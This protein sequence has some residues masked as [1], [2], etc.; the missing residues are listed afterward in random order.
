MRKRSTEIIQAVLQEGNKGLNLEKL[1]E[2]YKV[3]KKTLR[4]DINEIN[5]FLRTISAP[6]LIL[7]ERG[8][9]VKGHGFD[10]TLV[11]Q[12]L[13]EMNPYTY[14]LSSRERQIYIMMILSIGGQYMTMQ[15]IAEELYVS[16]ITI[17]NDIEAVKEEYRSAGVELMM[18]PGKGMLL[19]CTEDERVEILADLYREIGINV[20]NDGFFQRM[21][22]R[23]MHI[24]FEFSSIFS[25]MQDYMQMCS[26]VF[27]EDVFYEIALYMFVVFNFCL[28]VGSQAASEEAQ[29]E[30]EHMMLHTGQMLNVNVTQNMLNDLRAYIS[31]HKLI[32]FVKKVDEIELYKVVM[33]FV[34]NLEKI[35]HYELSDDPKLLDSLLMHIKNMKNWG[36][37]QVEFPEEYESYINYAHLEQAVAENAPILEQFLGYELNDNMKKSIVIHICVSII[38]NHRYMARASVIIVCPGS[39]ATGKYVEAQ[40]RNY[41]D[42]NIV[43]V[44]AVKEVNQKLKTLTAKVD[45]IISTVSLQ[46]DYCPVIK[47]HPFL[48]IE[49]L[50]LIQKVTFQK[51]SKLPFSISQKLSMM[52]SLIRD[53]IEDRRLAEL[54]CD[55]LSEVIEDYQASAPP[56][57]K[58]AIGELLEPDNILITEEDLTWRQAMH[59]ASEPLLRAGYIR[60]E[61]IE[62]AIQNVEEYGDYIV[63]SDGVA[64][65]HASKD[66]GVMK[67]CLSLLISKNGI[68]FSERS[69]RVYLLFCFASSGKNPYLDTLNEIMQIGHKDGRVQKIYSLNTIQEIYNEVVYGS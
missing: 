41:F 16:R 64:L 58:N 34:Q 50:N 24:Q 57:Q 32:S 30:I 69:N 10:E 23:R 6:E 9:I 17:V 55:K 19:N 49:D 54:L 28:E 21:I 47:V 36:E 67:D 13:Y 4:N 15:S 45:F 2:K 1:A 37:W 27:L 52:K 29:S 44:M 56:S 53:I 60:E 59:R 46:S 35:T 20:Q 22:L 5:Q 42:F 18:D 25:S 40:I 38:R 14:R 63:V 61:Y 68:V 65:A 31:K 8:E 12:S 11:E 62:K 48:K 39:M 7:T 51:Q 33:R 66:A 26:M 3:S 43:D